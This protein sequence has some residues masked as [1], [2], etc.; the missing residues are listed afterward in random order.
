MANEN[1]LELFYFLTNKC[2]YSN[3]W[4]TKK[5]NSNPY[6]QKVLDKSSK[7]GTGE[8]GEPD[9]IYC[10]ENEKFLILLENKYDVK[11]HQSNEYKEDN[12]IK[13]AVDGIKH[14]L[15]FFLE[16]NLDESTVHLAD[17]KILGLAFSGDIRDKY[18]KRMD[19]FYIQD[20]QIIDMNNHIFL[21]EEDYLSFFNNL[22]L[23]EITS[24]ISKSSK[25]INEKLRS[26]ETSNRS[27][28]LSALLISLLD[29]ESNDFRR[30]YKS[31]NPDTICDNIPRTVKKIL[32]EEQVE[33]EKIDI[34]INQL[35]FLKTDLDL[36]NKNILREILDELKDNV[37]PLF[38][39]KNNYDII[40]K[41]YSEFLRYAG[42]TD[43]KKGIVLT[44]QHITSL[45]TSLVELLDLSPK[46]VIFDPCC[47]TGS[48]LI[49]GMNKINDIIDHS[50]DGVD[51][52][53]K[54]KEEFKKEQLLGFEKN[55]T[56]YSLAISNM[57]FR[58]DG[59]SK[60]YNLDFF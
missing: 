38:K 32:K 14:Y 15:S 26:T 2:E 48:F 45:F 57:L 24:K 34:L 22:D 29:R 11:D 59:K 16:E 25:K 5:C 41:F 13:Y 40:G 23:E 54:K 44:P 49:A 58:G 50:G 28:L 21:N 20:N 33:S 55:S 17:W 47:G 60:V 52:R 53:N 1:E 27:I 8:R 18:N 9:L 31:S 6:V 51:L 19:T 46:D 7:R 56:M 36:R 35:S 37:I 4:E 43:V 30:N 39:K 10:N 12:P 42:I 3:R